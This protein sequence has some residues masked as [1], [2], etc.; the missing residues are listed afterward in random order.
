MRSKFKWIF[1]LLLAFSMQFSFAQEKTVTGVVTENGMPIPGVTVAI[2][3]T[4]VGTQTDFDGKYSIKAKSGQ[5][6]EFSYIGLKTQSVTVG[7]SNAVSVKMS[8]DDAVN[9]GEVVV[10]GYG[11][12][13]KEAFTGTAAKIDV[14]NIQA[15]AVSNVSQ[16]LKGEVAGVSVISTSGAPG[17]DASIRIRGIGSVNGNQ[18]PLY[19]VDGAPF[20]SDVSAINPADIESMIVLKDAAATSIYGSRGANG[21][22][23]IT[24]KQG[25]AGKSVVSV[26][27]RTS[28]NS[29]LLPQYDYIKSAEEYMEVSWSSLRTKGRLLGQANPESYAS[30]NLY[31]TAEGID[32]LYNIWN[33]TGDQL[34]DPAT[35]KFNPGVERR[36][37][38]TKWSDAA[39]GTGI[40]SEANIQFSGGTEKTKYAL[41]LGYLDDK[42]YSVNSGFKRY[43]TRINLEHKPKDW[44]TLS[45]NIA[46]TGAR[47]TRSGGDEN[48]ANSS[49]NVFNLISKTPA[50]YDVYLRDSNGDLVADPIFGGNQFDYG[51]ATGRRAWT[52]TNA[53]ADAKYNLSRTDGSTLLGNFNMAADIVKNLTFETRYSGQLQLDEDVNMSNQ[54]YGDQVAAGGRLDLSTDKTTNQNFLQLLR[55]N[56][57][58]GKHGV[59][60]F[61]AHESTDFRYKTL[62]SFAT[63]AI[64]PNAIDFD[65]YT[66]AGPKAR[67]YRL[68]STLESYFGQVNYNYDQKYYVTASARRDG[69][70]RFIENKWG[71]FGSVG[72]GWIIS[73]EDF[74]S[75]SNKINYLKLKGSY[76][77]IGDQGNSYTYGFQVYNIQPGESFSFSASPTKANP[78]LTWETS[79]IAQI[80]FESTFFNNRLDIDVDYYIKN[81][82]NLFFDQALPPFSGYTVTQINDGQLRNSGLEF[83]ISYQVFKPASAGDFGMSIGING[84]VMRNEITEMP[85]DKFTGKKKAIDGSYSEGHSVY[86]YY[87]REWAG[88]DPATGVGLW[89]L[90]YDDV[91]ND[92]IFNGGD[93][94]IANMVLFLSTNPDANVKKTV[95]SNYSQATLN[96]SGKSALPKM[97]GA[98]RLNAEYKNFD[99]NAQFSYS[100]GGYIYDSG[101]AELMGTGKQIGGDNFHTDIHN[102]WQEPGD[103]TNVPRASANFG[104]DSSF[105]SQSTRW[106]TKA[107]YLSLNNVKLGYTVPERFTNSMA[108]SKLNVY[109]SGDNLLM[110]SA[111]DGLNPT[112]VLQQS[113][114]SGIYMPMTTFSF[115][116]KIEF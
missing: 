92:G 110:L 81:T 50:I 62:S 42:G 99:I 72:L 61:V 32:P 97:R 40:R 3:G 108:I 98:F 45:G 27:F 54:F 12:T 41:S 34:I 66:T 116:A 11:K 103:I 78:D 49:G 33:A 74:L 93:A 24:T 106:L 26:D 75:S 76:G 64:V 16:A 102:A 71:T 37:T 68:G 13:T 77:L 96:Y 8:T 95:T 25:K 6:L 5:V 57:S 113:T 86:D 53:I 17:M 70:S 65:L 1:T 84:E 14:E 46:Y 90:S 4:T 52:A 36:Y 105:G 69:S 59:E 87:M 94:P 82:E 7:S 10:V 30:A 100:I 111:R 79:K 35:G 85:T 83:D 28:V 107:D 60:A 38:P 22:I 114:N 89:N 2:K 73:R 63:K 58:F 104:T 19:V 55:F 51:S 101:Y 112:T 29:L 91:N 44:L 67:S 9:L 43:T 109:V 80:G 48:E 31:G 39:F 20:S 88:V 23:L 21:V 47:Y 15:K 56:K 115:G 18:S